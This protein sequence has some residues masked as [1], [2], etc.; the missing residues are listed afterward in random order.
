MKRMANPSNMSAKRVCFNKDAKLDSSFS[1]N[2]VPPHHFHLG[3]DIYAAVTYFASSMQVHLRQYGRDE[4]NRLYP[5][6]KGVC[7]LPLLWQSL[8]NRIELINLP[9]SSTEETYVPKDALMISAVFIE[10]VSHIT[11]QRYFKQKDFSRKFIPGTCV[12]NENCWLEL[13]QIRKRITESSMSM[14]FDWSSITDVFECFGC[15]PEYANQLGHECITMDHET[16]LQ[17]YGDL[18]FFAMN[19]EQLIQDFIQQ[20][21]Q[22]SNYL[23]P[24]FVNKWDMLS[25]FDSAKSMYFASDP[26]RLY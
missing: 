13:A 22:M 24:M 4:N 6:K 7:M 17:L 23:N 1:D 3:Q 25:I 20:N 26:N 18:A 5:T 19:F 11:F 10:D 15:T 2:A 16:R 9:S 21:I 12:M 8:A 14:V